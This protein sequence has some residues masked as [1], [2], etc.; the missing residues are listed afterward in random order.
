MTAVASDGQEAE[1]EFRLLEPLRGGL[2]VEARPRTG[3]K[4]Q[5]RVHLAES[6]LPMLGDDVYGTPS[7]GVPRLMLHA[8]RLSLPHPLSGEPL[9]IE[10][11][12]PADFAEVLER[13]RRLDTRPG[14]KVTLDGPSREREGRR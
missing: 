4:H 14:R 9:V 6:G 12:Y 8:L 5:I 13:L 1:T 11:P 7:R 2:L 10:S 3:R